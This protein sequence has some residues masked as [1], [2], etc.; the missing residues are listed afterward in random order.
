M[1]SMAY[2]FQSFITVKFTDN[3][4]DTNN[5]AYKVNLSY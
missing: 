1:K 5:T 4:T 3:K 2:D